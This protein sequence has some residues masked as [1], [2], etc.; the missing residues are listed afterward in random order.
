MNT[1]LHANSPATPSPNSS[2]RVWRYGFVGVALFCVV[3]GLLIWAKLQ[4]VASV[5]RTVLADPPPS[6]EPS[7]STDLTR[8]PADNPR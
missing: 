2:G 3:F 6:A 8:V 4:L 1:R 5:P 7:P